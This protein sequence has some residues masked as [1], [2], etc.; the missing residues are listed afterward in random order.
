MELSINSLICW[1][2]QPK[3]KGIERLLW[4]N[5]PGDSLVFI[6][7]FGSAHAPFYR[8][9]AQL[10]AAFDQ[11]EFHFLDFDPYAY[12]NDQETSI[13]MKRRIL[14]DQAWQIIASLVQPPNERI[15]ESAER[16]PM[17]REILKSVK[18]SKA[19]VY[20]YLRRFWQC[21]QVKNALVPRYANS[22]AKGKERNSK[23]TIKRGRPS[24]I[25]GKCP[26]INIGP[27]ERAYFAMGIKKFYA[28]NNGGHK[29][30][31]RRAYDKT[32]AHYFKRGV[33]L[34]DGVPVPVIPPP[35]ECPTFR[36]FV[37]WYKKD[38]NLV[39]TLLAREGKKR[40]NLK[41]RAI[42]GHSTAMAFGPGSLYQIDS[43]I[44]DVNLISSLDSEIIG[45]PV[46]YLV[47]D[48]FSRLIAGF[49]VTLENAS[50]SAAMLAVENAATDK[51]MFCKQHGITLG[52]DEWPSHHLPECLLADRGELLGQ[53]A[54]N[55][56]A[57]LGISLSNTPPYR[58]DLKGI[59]ERGF[60][61]LNELN[62]HWLPGAS[63]S[64]AT[65][66]DRDPRLGATLN[67]NQLRKILIHCINL[68]NGSYMEQYSLNEFCIRDHVDP[69]PIELWRWG[70][71]NRTGAL[72]TMDRAI[73]WKHLLPTDQA[74]VTARGIKFR[75]VHYTSERAQKEQWHEKA[76]N[77]G[78]WKIEVSYDPRFNNHIWECKSGKF[79]KFD[80][81]ER[82]RTFAD[83]PLE[84]LEAYQWGRKESRALIRGEE[85]QRA[86][87]C[88][89]N[90]QMIIHEA[91]DRLDEAAKVKS[92]SARLGEIRDNRQVERDYERQCVRVASRHESTEPDTN[93]N[94]TKQTDGDLGEYPADW[95][96][97]L[98][99]N[100]IATT[101]KK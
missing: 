101:E 48:V 5:S 65:R 26:G 88:D 43:T 79:E 81:V 14:R 44:A 45:R 61:S 56:T 16:G 93:V 27:K 59:V 58:A 74:S 55:L 78:T 60:R 18:I 4:M 3:D 85:R 50:Y 49:A 36:Q 7:V 35:N 52:Q 67:L 54:D 62:F 64:C 63:N 19:T 17:V 99:Q 89:A 57:G 69:I 24:N 8:S 15:F 91:A 66:G 46:L 90:M 70:Q 76:R 71:T 22:G 9:R 37:Y 83:R 41:C 87:K 98:N 42:L 12:L 96:K 51:V 92:K 13:P 40:Y 31:L 29:P 77:G 25:S 53:K 80:L 33:Q 39:T 82:D 38:H 84:E 100:P 11:G 1:H 23:E 72:R 97:L 2:D 6:R 47:V 73:L 30:S 34:C 10:E 28:S 21:G 68:Y 20:K 86:A 95:F 75:G 94:P 32:I